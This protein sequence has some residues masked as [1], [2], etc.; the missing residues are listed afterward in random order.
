MK[1][2]NS[3]YRNSDV[4]PTGGDRQ[5]AVCLRPPFK[6]CVI[7]SFG[8]GRSFDETKNE[9]VRMSR[10]QFVKS[11]TDKTVGKCKRKYISDGKMEP[12]LRLND[13][14]SN[15]RLAIK[16]IGRKEKESMDAASADNL[17]AKILNGI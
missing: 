16:I 15:S 11:R 17:T 6:R 4:A 7:Y 12:R 13:R 5:N 9:Q 8:D 2:K 14:K 3:I 1:S 10:L